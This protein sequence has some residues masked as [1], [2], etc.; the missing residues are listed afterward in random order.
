MKITVLGSASGMAVPQR[1]ASAYLVETKRRLFLI[2]AG[3]GVSQQLVRFGLDHNRID[4]VFISHT[5]PDHAAGLLG[6][7]QLMHLT[8]RKTL[9]RIYLPQGVLPG[10]DS[11]FPYFYIF[12]EKWPFRFE[13]IPISEETLLDEDGFRM[14]AIPNGH[15]S[16]NRQIAKK[17]GVGSDSYSFCFSEKEKGTIIYTSD[18]DSLTHLTKSSRGADVLISEC[19]HVSIEKVR[20]FARAAGI[21][22]VILTHIPPEL[23]KTATSEKQQ[24]GSPVVE[25]ASD[26]YVIEV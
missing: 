25:F 3:D 23:E 22:R 15:L 16:G 13:L 19:Y 18:V 11:I 9:L 6:L 4:T 26:G 21:Y 14:S 17:F 24:V 10:F 7:L 8:E 12:Q 5:H 1:N 2:D 20:T